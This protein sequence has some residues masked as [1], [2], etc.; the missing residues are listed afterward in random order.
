MELSLVYRARKN[1]M[2]LD[3][4]HEYRRSVA[5]DLSNSP[6]PLVFDL[7]G[8]S[9]RAR[10]GRTLARQAYGKGGALFGLKDFD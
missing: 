4:G 5:I 10:E 7:L 8:G 9:I 3:R 6:N 1:T 2:W